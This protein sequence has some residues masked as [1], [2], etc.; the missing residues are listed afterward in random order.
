VPVI[1]HDDVEAAANF[2][3]PMLAL[4]VGGMGA[5]GANF[6][7]DVLARMGWE[8][9]CHTIQNLYLEGNKDEAISAIPLAMVE[10]VALVGPADKIKEEIP[11]WA[12][13]VIT[14][15]LVSGDAN[16]VRQIHEWVNG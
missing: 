5:K 4:Y 3:R 6:H 7:F 15:L 1:P 9:E 13:T 10:D 16:L 11:K 12:E 14:T 2:V 8:S